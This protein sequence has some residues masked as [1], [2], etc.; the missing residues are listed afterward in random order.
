[1][2]KSLNV[3][4]LLLSTLA[5]LCIPQSLLADS[6][7]EH[8][9]ELTADQLAALQ[10]AADRFTVQPVEP[11]LGYARSISTTAPPVQKRQL[12]KPVST[13][14]RL[15]LTLQL[16]D[17]RPTEKPVSL[18]NQGPWL[19][20]NGL[21]IN[22]QQLI[23]A[24]Q[25]VSV[26]GLDPNQYALPEILRS[27]ETL[28]DLERLET[29][30]G[31]GQRSGHPP[32]SDSLMT[33]LSRQM[34]QAF[35]KLA[36]HLGQGV[37]DARAT[38]EELYRDVP[39]VDPHALLDSVRTGRTNALQALDSVTPHHPP[40]RRLTSRMRNLLTEAASGTQRPII[41]PHIKPNSLLSLPDLYAIKSRL[42]GTGD[43]TLKDS[44]S[45]YFDSQL[46]TA[47]RGFQRRHGLT[48]SGRLDLRTRRALDLSI[49]EEIQ[50]IALSLERWRWMPRDLGHRHIFINIPDYH[51]EYRVGNDTR[52]SMRAVVGAVEHQT[53][54][55]SRDMSYMEFNPT[56]TVPSSIANREL[57]P[58][59]RQ[60]PGYLVSRQ[61]DF[62][63]RVGDTWVA[64]PPE[65]ITL[66]ELN[67]EPFPYLLRQRG[68]PK[69]TLGRMKF[70]MPNPHAIYLHDTQAKKHFTFN[71]RA[72]SHG[73]IR[74]SDPDALANLLLSEDGYSQSTISQ[75]LQ[76]GKTKRVHLRTPVPTH[77]TYF[78]TWIDDNGA[79][80]R[81]PDIYHQ[82]QALLSALQASGTLLSV[83]REPRPAL[84]LLQ[85]LSSSN[86]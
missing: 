67:T 36:R 16:S 6:R 45:P 55:F 80:Q 46:V 19:T 47:L 40:Y 65:R 39:D 76:G 14:H 33:T 51:V 75:S 2:E 13:E 73:C 23:R 41:D 15:D 84:S 59:E 70:M 58:K 57:I 48:D 74:L 68:G 85:G 35:V 27:L 63:E 12:F 7:S 37:V 17:S 30:A 26:H 42:V 10:A 34:D 56:W 61:F 43:L 52:L 78:T 1:M 86:S 71:D 20:S 53:P 22:A 49:E 28:S 38:Q 66:A 82:D 54:S 62:L 64:V 8:P 44:A 29:H 21:S 60:Q 69:N 32:G 4:V 5:A 31:Q 11:L 50:A 3:R 24:I 18:E 9:A 81:R 77:L 79:L 25:D 83:P 72:Y